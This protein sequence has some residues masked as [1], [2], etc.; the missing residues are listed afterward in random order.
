MIKI[1]ILSF[2]NQEDH[3]V[4]SHVQTNSISGSW[5][6]RV[7]LIIYKKGSNFDKKSIMVK[8]GFFVCFTFWFVKLVQTYQKKKKKKWFYVVSFFFLHLGQVVIPN[9]VWEP[10]EVYSLKK[11]LEVDGK[12]Y[13]FFLPIY[14]FQNN[15]Q[16]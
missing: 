7:E 15:W 3:W 14:S 4:T 6:V 9:N 2:R 1:C 5:W 16:S 12:Y 8:W 11:D 13:L 10:G